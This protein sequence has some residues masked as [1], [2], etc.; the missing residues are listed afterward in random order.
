MHPRGSRP[1]RV[2]RQTIFPHREAVHRH[3]DT[4]NRHFPLF[5]APGERIE[6]ILVRTSK[7]SLRLAMIQQAA[8]PVYI[9]TS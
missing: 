1:L 9:Y 7:N 2:L 5:F 4:D 6:R 3:L 8:A